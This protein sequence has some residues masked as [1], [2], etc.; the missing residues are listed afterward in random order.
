MLE[1]GSV[2]AK[3]TKSILSKNLMDACLGA[4]FWYFF[5][6]GFAFGEDSGDGW[7][8]KSHFGGAGEGFSVQRLASYTSNT[9]YTLPETEVGSL[10]AWW[11]FQFS[12]CATAATI[13]SGAV[14]ERMDIRAYFVYTIVISGLVY[15]IVAHW[16][17]GPG[18]WAQSIEADEGRT[19]GVIDFAG[20]GV[21]HMTG[22]MAALVGAAILGP[23]KY[24]FDG[25]KDST[26]GKVLDWTGQ[27]AAFQSLGTLILWV[28][29]YGFNCVSTGAISGNGITAGHVAMTTTI[30]AATGGVS[31]MILGRLLRGTWD[32]VCCNNGILSGLVAITAGCA[33]VEPMGA[34]FIGI[35]AAPVYLLSSNLLVRLKVDDVID[36]A[37]VHLFCG[38]WGVIAPGLFAGVAAGDTEVPCGIFYTDAYYMKPD[39][40]ESPIKYRACGGMQGFQLGAQLSFIL[41]VVVWVGVM[42]AA[43]FGALRVAGILRVSAEDEEIGLDAAEH[44]GGAYA[45]AD[46][47]RAASVDAVSQED[48][49]VALGSA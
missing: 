27:N 23:R 44:G 22:G 17:W 10:S 35:I 9:T 21:V 36:A 7:I 33:V 12:F 25:T 18:G 39:G 20:S 13:V 1:V 14:A 45:G 3:N 29:W 6:Y 19:V 30:S 5:G 40:S 24:R 4:I 34:F 15:P 47:K 46:R 2:A 41:A 26:T 32:P 43:T 11:V 42:A 48:L 16:A 8:G 38:M 28:G 31:T 37:P 49:E